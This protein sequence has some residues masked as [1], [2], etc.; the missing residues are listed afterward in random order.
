MNNVRFMRLCKGRQTNKQTIPP[1]PPPPP[2][3]KKSEKMSCVEK[4]KTSWALV[5]ARHSF[6]H[7]D[8]DDDDDDDDVGLNV[9]GCRADILRTNCNKLLK[10]RINGVGVGGGGGDG[11][12][13]SFVQCV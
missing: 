3:K 4:C 8:D 6:S 12:R 1:P 7:N 13:F 9:L 5:F 11:G 10:L 2:K